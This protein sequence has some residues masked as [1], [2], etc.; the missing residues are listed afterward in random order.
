MTVQTQYLALP[1]P[2]S[3]AP[4]LQNT[5]AIVSYVSAFENQPE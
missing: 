1:L 4:S 5:L 3:S 2:S